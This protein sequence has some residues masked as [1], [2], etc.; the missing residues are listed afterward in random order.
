MTRIRNLIIPVQI[1][2]DNQKVNIAA[3]LPGSAGEAVGVVLSATAVA[4]S[5]TKTGIGRVSLS[6]N[7]RASNPFGAMVMATTGSGFSM[8]SMHPI[9]L[10]MDLM[11]NSHV[12]GYYIDNGISVVPYTLRIYIVYKTKD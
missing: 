5:A 9:P 12:N 7:N 1:T 8:K 3:Q 2:A 11:P 10:K 6:F 4:D